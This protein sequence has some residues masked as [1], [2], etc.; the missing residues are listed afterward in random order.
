M[1]SHGGAAAL[2]CIV[3]FLAEICAGGEENRWDTARRFMDFARRLECIVHRLAREPELLSSP[4]VRTALGGV[5]ADLDAARPTI[6]V[7]RTRSPIYILIH[8]VPLFEVL[9]S[10]A[11]SIAAWLALLDAPLSTLPDLSKKVSDLSRDMDQ[12]HH[13]VTDTEE[14]VY[15]GLQRVA[16][17]AKQSSKAVL[18]ATVMDLARALGIDPT[19]H[20]KLGE[21][22]KLLKVDLSGLSSVAERRILVSLEKTLHDWSREPS[23]AGGLV[24]SSFEEEAQ[25]SPFN[26]FL[27]PLTKEVMKDP[28][29][30]ESSQTYERAAIRH[31]LDRCS[32]DERDP[33]C[34][35]TGLILQSLEL[36]PN[37]GLSG[38]IEEWVNRNVE[39]QIKLALQYLGEE[40]SCPV[41]RIEMVLDNVYR[42]SEEHPAYRYKVRNSGIVNLLVR[43]LKDQSSKIGSELRGKTLM[44][45]LSM[46]KDGESKQIML[47]EGIIKLVI[48]SLIGRSEMEKEYALKLLLE[49]SNE[50][51]YCT[52]IALEKGA[53]VLLSSIAENPDYPT[54]SNLAEEVLAN[55]EKVEDNVQHLAMAGRFQ[56]LVTR[57][58]SGAEDIKLETATLLGKMSLTN[59]GKDYITR[60][61]G[62]ILVDMLSCSQEQKKSSLHAL[63]NLSTLDESAAILVD[64]GIL[65]ALTNILFSK[66]Q[67]FFTE[68]NELAASTIANIVSKSGH[69][70]F[71]FAD[72]E[73]HHMQSEFI[74]HKLLDLLSNSSCRCQAAILHILCG[75]VSSPR[76]SDISASC[77]KSSDG[78]KSLVHYVEHPEIKHRVY[79]CRL[80]SLL[81][82]KLGHAFS[83]EFRAYVK[84]V[85]LRIKLLDADS[86][87]EETCEIACLLANLSFSDDEVKTVLGYDLLAW[88]IAKLI[89]QQSNSS[90]R[91][92][93]RGRRIVYGLLGLLL[94]Y[95]RSSDLEIIAIVQKN[96]IMSIFLEQLSSHSHSRWKH[97]AALGLKYLSESIRASVATDLLEPQLQHGLCSPFLLLCGRRTMAPILCPLHE[98]PC[99]KCNSF[100]LLKGNAIKPLIDLMGDDN[101]DV[102]L[103]AVEA[104]STVLLDVQ[105]IKN[106][107]EELEQLGVF[108]AMIHLFKEVR[109]GK[110]QEHVTLLVEKFFQ[111]E[112]IAMDY[113]NDQGLVMALIGA[114]KYGNA[115]TKRYAQDA[116]ANLRVL[117]GGIKV[118][119]NQGKK[120]N[121]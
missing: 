77:I 92:S 23:L 34:P 24:V 113:S 54:L 121:R 52:K 42:I 7:Y 61:G 58:C 55:L 14:R 41:E 11:T 36:K 68:T 59:I 88:T 29:V 21:Q 117:S 97:Q 27:C 28:V 100:C 65:P 101:M 1:T 2:E 93:R 118:S 104:L 3:L 39:I 38:A 83:E 99:D 43:Q 110:L 19:D 15:A 63:V 60:Q 17:D 87:P 9:S 51:D 6:S 16:A 95:A 5:A 46:V 67:D 73:G 114:M 72:K 49:F 103:A 62:Q 91:N 35:V 31:W 45:M 98:A 48:R 50:L 112:M 20:T 102:Q 69:W 90:G 84:I 30:I 33:T 111:V 22:I 75:I 57:L 86:S 56:P 18:S 13:K 78:I 25:I 119:S 47:E 81:S 85:S 64:F 10:R 76:A 107:K 70:E 108:D 44:V 32:E 109:P 79:S 8:C 4:A 40:T 89:E 105:S 80:L 53:L 82:E 12:P 96:Q 26:N 37:I 106:A 66:Q 116:L 94:H 74:M 71:S 120:R 115:N